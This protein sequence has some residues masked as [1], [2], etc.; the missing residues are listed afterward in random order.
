MF[1]QPFSIPAILIAILS[2]PLIVGLIPR[3]RV[4][5]VRTP[6]TLSTDERWYRANR[7]GGCALVLASAV[8]LAVAVLVPHAPPPNDS[9]AVWLL[10]VAAFLGPLIASLVATRRYARAV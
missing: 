4:Y 5:G 8:Y 1:A 6:N 3:N 9:L 7:F 2:L 10:H